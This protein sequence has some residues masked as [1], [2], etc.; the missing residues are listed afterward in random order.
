MKLFQSLK[1]RIMPKQEKERFIEIAPRIYAFN[2]PSESR[3]GALQENFSRIT[4]DYKIWNVSEYTYSAK[5]FDY[6]VA[7]YSRP[8]LPCPSLHDLLIIAQ[9][10]ANWL[11]AKPDHLLFVHCQI[12]FARSALVLICLLFLLR[13]EKDIRS[14]EE[15]V[16]QSLN[17]S[18]LNN[19]KLYLKYFEGCLRD[20]PIN[21]HPLLIK[22]ISISEIP[23]IRLLKEHAEDPVYASAP[24]FRPYLQIFQGQKIL[25]NSIER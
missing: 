21:K 19:H 14:L 10:M 11:D 9:E 2:F 13:F 22:S 23:F 4:V 20:V 7:D 24:A 6:K 5:N 18:L 12:S 3:L 15:R 16:A 1:E 25:Y 8:G 17:T